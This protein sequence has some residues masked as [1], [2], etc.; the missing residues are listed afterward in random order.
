MSVAPRRRPVHGL[1]AL[2]PGLLA[3]VLVARA[4]RRLVDRQVAGMRTLTGTPLGWTAPDADGYHGRRYGAARRDA[5]GLVRLVVLGDSLAAGLGATRPVHTPGARLA[6]ALARRSRR[7]VH[8]RTVARVGAE[9]ADLD[10]QVRRLGPHAR[11]D[12][13]LVIVGGNDVLHRVPPARSASE[14]R[15]CVD[16]LRARGAQVVVG[17]CPDLGA[18]RHVPQPLRTWASLASRRTAAAQVRALAGHDGVQ[19]VHLAAEVGPFFVAD[20]DRLLALD[21]FHPSS[22]G[23]RRV[24]RVLMPAVGD[25]LA[26]A[27]REAGRAAVRTTT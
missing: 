23:Y 8:L 14:L 11:P 1:L 7:P 10:R 5:P 21:R 20:P 27:D 17:A 4:A 9:S 2:L 26:A 12:L 22:L 6:R 15:A 18:L 19:V 25:A 16:A 3:A 13:A 24:A